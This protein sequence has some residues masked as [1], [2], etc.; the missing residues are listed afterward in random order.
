MLFRAVLIAPDL[1]ILP[2]LNIYRKYYGTRM[3]LV[4]GGGQ[5]YGHRCQDG[6][7]GSRRPGAQLQAHGRNH[8]T[9]M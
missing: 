9:V 1:L 8:R 2:I 5:R 7:L 3:M 6:T 4:E